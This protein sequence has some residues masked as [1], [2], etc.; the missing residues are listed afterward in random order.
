CSSSSRASSSSVNPTSANP[1]RL[2]RAPVEGS[3]PLFIRAGD[4]SVGGSGSHGPS[5]NPLAPCGPRTNGAPP[6]AAFWRNRRTRDHLQKT[7]KIPVPR[8]REP[9]A[10]ARPHGARAGL[11]I[12]WFQR[13]NPRLRRGFHV[14]IQTPLA[15]LLLDDDLRRARHLIA[16]GRFG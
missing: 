2:M 8:R 16:A 9:A 5:P 1:R 15:D 13:K 11:C 14:R 6:P 7:G 10:R 4:V 12:V 3:V